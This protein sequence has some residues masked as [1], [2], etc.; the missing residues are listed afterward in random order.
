M[1]WWI[2][3]VMLPLCAFGVWWFARRPWELVLD[4]LNHDQAR[5]DFRR[6]REHLEARFITSLCLSEPI[7]GIR[8]EDAH[9]HDEIQW[10]RDRRSRCF[11]ALVGVHFDPSPFSDPED[12][13]LYATA[14]FEY[15]KGRW[16]AEGLRLPAMLPQEACLRTQ[17]F[18]PLVIPPHRA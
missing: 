14:V 17:R 7:E 3:M 15:R 6:R 5:V 13:N 2:G 18:V 8:W 4:D 1:F 10:A 9:W 12:P 11:L 16:R